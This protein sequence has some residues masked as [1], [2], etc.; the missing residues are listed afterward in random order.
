MTIAEAF[1]QYLRQCEEDALPAGVDSSVVER[2][3]Y[4]GAIKATETISSKGETTEGVRVVCLK[5]V[6]E[7]L[8]WLRTNMRKGWSS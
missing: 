1:E 2:A 6:D 4:A 8:S 3:F 7:T 5:I